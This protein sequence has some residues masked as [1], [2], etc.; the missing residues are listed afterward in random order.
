M[1][2]LSLDSMQANTVAWKLICCSNVNS[3][4]IWSKS[5]FHVACWSLYHGYHFGWIRVLCQP[6]FHSV[7]PS[8]PIILQLTPHKR[9]TISS[10]AL[11]RY[12]SYVYRCNDTSNNGHPNIGYK[13]ITATGILYQ[14]HWCMDGRLFD[15]RFRSAARIRFGQLCVTLR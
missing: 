15:I 10:N 4:T 7:S 1:I 5:I 8:N 9:T 6:V 2:T 11:I 12:L 13:C 3:H 14:G